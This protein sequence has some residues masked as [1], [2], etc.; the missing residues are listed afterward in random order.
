[1]KKSQLKSKAGIFAA[2]TLAFSTL[3]LDGCAS[4]KCLEYAD[5]TYQVE[6]CDRYSNTGWC[7]ARH[8]ES[9]TQRVCVRR[10]EPKK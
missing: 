10:E 6:V 5:R 8:W 7:A 4:G 2:A 9:R 3:L 1:M